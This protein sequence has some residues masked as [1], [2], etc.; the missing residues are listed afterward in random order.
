MPR[1][2]SCCKPRRRPPPSGEN[3]SGNKYSFTSHQPWERTALVGVCMWDECRPLS[4]NERCLVWMGELQPGFGLVWTLGDKSLTPV[5]FAAHRSPIHPSLH[6]ALVP[7]LS[8]PRRLSC[9]KIPRY[10][11]C[12]PALSFPSRE[13]ESRFRST[14]KRKSSISTVTSTAKYR[15]A[16]QP[17]RYVS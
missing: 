3:L 9:V 12:V 13:S 8:F 6:S 17:Q 4:L 16:R 1:E 11:C 7:L 10:S 2:S 14:N 15:Q 5:W